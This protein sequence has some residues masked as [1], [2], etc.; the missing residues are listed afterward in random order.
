MDARATL[1]ALTEAA[2]AHDLERIAQVSGNDR[3][4]ASFG[5][6]LGAFPDASVEVEWTLAEGSRAT[7][8]AAVRG[9][10]QGEWRGLAPTGKPID[11]RGMLAIEVAPD[12][13]VSDLWVATDW[14]GIA[15]QIG[16]PLALPDSP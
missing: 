2:N 8:W 14:L 10:H 7:G 1:L 15:M 9:T 12:G 6:L 5:Q 3:V 16:V 4:V 13:T 11:V